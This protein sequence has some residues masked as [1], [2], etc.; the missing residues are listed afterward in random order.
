MKIYFTRHGESQANL[1]HVISNRSLPHSLT[2]TGL[3]QAAALAEKLR[4]CAM[5]HIYSSPVPRA[6]ETSAI[7]GGRLG[8]DYQVVD[9][10]REYD[11]GIWEGRSDEAAWQ[12]WQ[13][14]FDAWT[15]HKRLDQRLEGGE[16]FYDVRDRFVPFIEDL[17]KL[18]GAA[19]ENCVCVSHGGTYWMM[20]PLVL[21]NIDTGWITRYGFAYTTCIVAEARD[22]GLVCLEWNGVKTL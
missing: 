10:L 8:L 18:Y 20:L 19:G 11:C 14:L 21:K 2:P 16:S 7:L 4:P 1:L 22:D 15:I 3:Q 5:S 12:H 9:A 13:E 17:V 6:V